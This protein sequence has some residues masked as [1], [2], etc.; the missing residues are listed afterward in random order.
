MIFSFSIKKEGV[1]LIIS[2]TPQF[3]YRKPKRFGILLMK[4]VFLTFFEEKIVFFCQRLDFIAKDE[5]FL[6]S[7]GNKLLL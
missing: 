5:G 1:L 4:T 3:F 7:N 2:R 6:I